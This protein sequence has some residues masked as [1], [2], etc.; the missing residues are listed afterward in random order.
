MSDI[1]ILLKAIHFAADKHRDQRRKDANASPYINHPIHVAQIVNEVGETDDPEILAGAVLHDTVEDT[2]TSLAEITNIFGERVARIVNEVTDDKSLPKADRKR[3]QIEHAKYL[4][5][6]A[7]LVKLADKIS[8]I[9]DVI[10]NPPD[11]WDDLRRQEYL[12]WA[13]KVVSSCPRVNEALYE[14]F[15]QVLESASSQGPVES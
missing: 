13:S 3:I 8:N 6:E 9:Q 7:A 1:S 4:S 10:S 12:D 14:M 11:G 15:Y 5:P 2:E